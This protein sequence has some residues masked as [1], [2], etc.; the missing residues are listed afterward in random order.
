MTS[1]CMAGIFCAITSRRSVLS[2]EYWAL[3]ASAANAFIFYRRTREIKVLSG[4]L[5][6]VM[7][8]LY[9]KM[10]RRGY[11]LKLYSISYKYCTVFSMQGDLEYNNVKEFFSFLSI[12]TYTQNLP[13]RTHLTEMKSKT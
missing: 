5:K 11:F 8:Q 6:Q 2:V 12:H 3:V 7:D 10:G 1:S 4:Q 13:K 9:I